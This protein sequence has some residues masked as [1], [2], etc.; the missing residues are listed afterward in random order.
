MNE[1]IASIVLAFWLILKHCCLC[2]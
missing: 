2:T 1:S